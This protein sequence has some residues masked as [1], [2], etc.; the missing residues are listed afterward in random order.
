VYNWG[1]GVVSRMLRSVLVFLL[2]SYGSPHSYLT[3]A[4]D[5]DMLFVYI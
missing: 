2:K 1:G 5:S 3:D 4:L